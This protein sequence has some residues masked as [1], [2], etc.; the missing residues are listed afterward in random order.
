MWIKERNV[1]ES[2]DIIRD[3]SSICALKGGPIA[4]EL[5]ALVQSGLYREV[6]DFQFN[7]SSLTV[8]FWLD[9]MVYAR[10]IQGLFSKFEKLDL[11]FDKELTASLKFAEA[12]RRCFE[13]NKT[14]SYHARKPHLCD[15]DVSSVLFGAARKIS[16]VLGDL[17]SLEDLQP[18]F[19]PG[20]NTNVKGTLACARAKLGVAL[21][22]SHNMS[23][24]VGDY[25]SE[26]PMWAALA[27][28]DETE[29]SYICP[30]RVVP[31]KLV[32]VPKNAKTFRSIIVEPLLNSFFQKGFGSYIR[33]RL[34]LSNV[35]LRDQSRNQ[36]LA[37][38][39]SI[40]GSL[41][42]VDLSSAS[43]CISSELVWQLLP[44]EWADA[45][46][47][48]RTSE[49]VLPPLL[50]GRE[51]LFPDG[52]VKSSGTILQ[53]EKFSSMGNGYTFE[54][55]SL[56]FYGLA[57]SVCR[58][59]HISTVDVSIYGDD[60]I[61]PVRAVPLLQKVLS[62]CGFDFNLS[63]SFW[64]GP[65]RESCGADYLHGFDIRPFYLKTLISD[66]ILYS[67]HNWFLRHGERELAQACRGY[68]DPNEILTGP[69]GFGDGHL[70]GS[71][72][73]RRNRLSSR[74]GWGGGYFDTYTLNPVRFKKPLP[75][76][77][78]LPVYSV[79]TRSGKDS[80]TDPNV[81]RGSR[82]YAKVSI[83]TLTESVFR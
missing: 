44:Y 66:R 63:K 9:D 75:G 40:Y 29:M 54:L 77:A 52:R 79:Y 5:N 53:L 7:Y 73:L 18:S 33:D 74:S 1:R 67:M 55:E 46:S 21:E 4:K 39:G 70:I 80:P 38:E 32:F 72:Q 49:V 83:Y 34:A 27:S 25:L 8:D 12:E 20:A 45:L 48:L 57:Y 61:V 28:T 41:A 35:N 2:L 31:G 56:L 68:C 58:H 43:D 30:V 11:G 16:R 76:D 6:V 24:T 78:V 17:P 59:L 26:V 13:T 81:V 51:D 50:Q 71:H 3:L 60:I 23:P 22:C 62:Y 14:L 10:Q 42:T 82:G 15:S 65:F 36:Y 47:K 37:L 19:G 69:D 64:E